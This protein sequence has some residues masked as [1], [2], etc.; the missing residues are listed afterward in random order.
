MKALF[1]EQFR[2][3]EWANNKLLAFAS[4]KNLTNNRINPIFSHLTL[5]QVIWCDRLH[6]KPTAQD[7]NEWTTWP[8]EDIVDKCNQTNA[9]LLAFVNDH[10]DNDFGEKIKF[11]NTSG[12]HYHRQV[13]QVLTHVLQ[14]TNFHRGQIV[15]LIHQGENIITPSLDFIDFVNS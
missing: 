6:G 9:D 14:Y 5:A 12:T 2:Y 1:Q 8:W 3:N 10:A 13:R 4:E 15:G 7:I 11:I